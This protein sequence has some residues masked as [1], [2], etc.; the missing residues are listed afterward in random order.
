MIRPS[1]LAVLCCIIAFTAIIPHPA[2]AQQAPPTPDAK[3]EEK[4]N[5]PHVRLICVAAIKEDQDVILAS[6]NEAG[7]WKEL[8]TSQIR[9]SFI[10]EWIPA[11]VG[12]L[13]VAVKDKDTLKSIGKF[14]FPSD[15]R[16]AMA[17]LLPAP[18]NAS[19]SAFAVDPE[20]LA[21]AK[22]SVLA[23]NFSKQTGYLLLGTTKVT[24]ASG[25]R[26]VAKPIPEA[27]GMYRFMVAYQNEENQAVTC[28]DRYLPAS[29][30]SRELLF[31]FPDPV[32]GLKVM[33]LPM[34][35]D[36]D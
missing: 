3:A 20:K 7:E 4:K 21:F 6:R 27:N 23:V 17:V 14:T 8:G 28:Y 15:C 11:Q 35:G 31:L 19:Y 29:N 13:H 5:K 16:R 30:D 34:F 1:L 9:S 32:Q 36:L 25:Q 12:E 18:D 33:N 2:A 10:T 24:V 22:G 26:V